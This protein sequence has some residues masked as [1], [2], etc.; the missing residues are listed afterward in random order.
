MKPILKNI[1]PEY[2]SKVDYCSKSPESLFGCKYNKACYWHDRQYRNQI[3]NRQSRFMADLCLWGNI[4]K[5]SWKVR[6][7]SIVWSWWVGHKY[8]WAVRLFAG[9]CY[10]D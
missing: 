1:A 5:E 6:K 9:G 10:N 3:V 4:I 2:N 7:T 8:F